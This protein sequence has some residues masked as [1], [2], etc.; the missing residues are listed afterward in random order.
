M[1]SLAMCITYQKLSFDIFNGR[2]FTKYLHGTWSL[3]NILMILFWFFSVLLTYTMYFLAIEIYPCYLVWWSRVTYQVTPR[4]LNLRVRSG[5]N[6]TLMQQLQVTTFFF[7]LQYIILYL[8]LK[9]NYHSL[10]SLNTLWY[11]YLSL[12][13]IKMCV[14]LRACRMLTHYLLESFPK[15]SI[16]NCI[17]Y[18]VHRAV[19]VTNPE[20]E[21]E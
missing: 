2:K 10:S 18:G 9:K 11:L 21:I 16:E 5:R 1:K 14:H 6:S 4:K 3:L 13:H 12:T 17:N 7:F 20:K 8:Y 19:A 15:V